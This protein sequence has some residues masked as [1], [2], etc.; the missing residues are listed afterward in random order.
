LHDF[1]QKWRLSIEGQ[2][3]KAV[4]LR[5]GEFG[6]D[7][8]KVFKGDIRAIAPDLAMSAGTLTELACKGVV[9]GIHSNLGGR[10]ILKS[11][12]PQC[13]AFW[14]ISKGLLHSSKTLFCSASKSQQNVVKKI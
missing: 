8:P 5:A 9:I 4:F 13:T 12:V 14:R 1:E 6:R 10:L 7:L 2:Y 3:R 11:A